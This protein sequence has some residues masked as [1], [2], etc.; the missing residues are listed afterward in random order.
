MNVTLF[1]YTTTTPTRT[2]A[3]PCPPTFKECTP[4][5]PWCGLFRSLHPPPPT[6]IRPPM[7]NHLHLRTSVVVRFQPTVSRSPAPHLGPPGLPV[8][9]LHPAPSPFDSYNSP[10]SGFVTVADDGTPC[11]GFRQ[12]TSTAGATG[13]NPN[14]SPWDVPME[15]RC[16]LRPRHRR[17]QPF[18]NLLRGPRMPPPPPIQCWPCAI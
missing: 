9:H 11:A 16:K 14:A 7:C 6:H 1:L 5:N 3:H 18:S 15:L 12:C 10:C 4:T 2:S 8:P 17:F 13:L